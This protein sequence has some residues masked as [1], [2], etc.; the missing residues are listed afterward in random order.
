MLVDKPINA[1]KGKI[2]LLHQPREVWSDRHSNPPTIE[3][4]NIFRAEAQRLVASPDAHEADADY[5]LGEI[6]VVCSSFLTSK[7]WSP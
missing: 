6:R 1:A 2:F 5:V 7:R 4:A 3:D